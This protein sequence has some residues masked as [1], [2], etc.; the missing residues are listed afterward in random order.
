VE[1]HVVEVDVL[2]QL[3]ELVADGLR[4]LPGGFAQK[5]ERRVRMMAGACTLIV[6][7]RLGDT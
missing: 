4:L 7:E 1:A 6:S 3:Q 5:R 2:L